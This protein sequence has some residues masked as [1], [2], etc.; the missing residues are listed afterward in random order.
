MLFSEDK[1]V[2]SLDALTKT[3]VIPNLLKILNLYV[4]PQISENKSSRFIKRNKI[5]HLELEEIFLKYDRVENEAG[6]Q[7]EKR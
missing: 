4:Y 5:N 1:D 2:Y 3:V 6:E 7:K